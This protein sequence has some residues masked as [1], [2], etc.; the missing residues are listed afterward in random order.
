MNSTNVVA[1][2]NNTVFEYSFPGGG[3]KLTEKDKVAL[4]SITMYNS[5]P[6]ISTVYVNDSFQYR[7]VDNS[8]FTVTLATGFYEILDI[9]NAMHQTMLNNGHYLV[10]NATGNYVW[11]LTMAVNAATYN[12]DVVTYRLTSA[13][14]PIGVG[15]TQYTFGTSSNGTPAWTNPST[16][17]YPQLVVLSNGFRQVIGFDAGSYPS[18]LVIPTVPNITT[19]STSVPQVNPLSAYTVKCNLVNNAYSI[20]NNVLYSFSPTGAFGAQ[21][22]T[23][24]NEYA[25]I[26]VSPAYYNVFRVELTDQNNRGVVILDPNIIILIIIKGE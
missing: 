19:S 24:P 13:L 16:N 25:F 5:S 7:W 12:I 10:E 26:D 2:T 3:V 21:F 1:G 15:T 22:T 17:A 20:P 14:F 8:L 6:N 11:F 9:N 23:A 4:A 18:S